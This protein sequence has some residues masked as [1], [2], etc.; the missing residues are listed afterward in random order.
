MKKNWKEKLYT[1]IFEADTKAGKL[2]DVALLW[3]IVLSVLVVLLESDQTISRDYRTY[4]QVAEWVF[5]ILFTLEYILRIVSVEKPIRY[6]GSFFG[7]VDFLSIVPTYLSLF[8]PGSQFLLVIRAIRLLRVF[9]VLKL[10]RYSQESQILL[11]ALSASRAKITVFL[12]AV[13]TM[14]LIVGTLMYMVEEGN[15]GFSSIFSS[16]YW[17][18]VTMTTVGFGD[19]VP[20]TTLGKFLASIVMI[21]GYGII[22]VPTGIVSVELSHIVRGEE[23]RACKI[24]HTNLHAGGAKFCHECGTKT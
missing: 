23:S 9:R 1:V 24:C 20:V 21:M 22:A 12:G 5:T 14:I 6:I 3:T 19:A 10:V 2:F 17:A 13:L 11:K 4:L 7:I 15:P 16:M 18:V 8:V